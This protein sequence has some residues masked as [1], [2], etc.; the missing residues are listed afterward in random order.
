MANGAELAMI[1]RAKDEAGPVF[2]SVKGKAGGL[3]SGVGSM[4]DGI[5]RAGL[6]VGGIV[7]IG[8]AIAGVAS[9]MVSGN[10]EM[11]TYQTQLGTLLGGADKAKER[12]QQL[13][14]IGAETP[15]D[16]PQLVAAEKIMAGFGLTT[17]KTQQLTGRSLDDYRR[18]IGDMAAATGAPLDEVTLL[19]SK[20][21]SGATGEAISR[22]QELGIVTREQMAA[23]GV[24]FSKSGELVT[25]IPQAMKIAM[26]LANEKMGGGMKALSSTFAG[27]MSTLSDNFGQAKVLLMAPIF[28]VLRNGLT[29]VNEMLSS[30]TFTSA[31]T[32]MAET[33]AAAVKGMV[34]GIGAAMTALGPIFTQ[35]FS[36]DWIGA[37]SN[38]GALIGPALEGIGQTI[39]TTVEGWATAF[40][41]W[42]DGAD[43]GMIS[44]LA[45][46]AI[47]L[48]TWIL[49]A[50]AAIVEK[51]G[52][53]AGAFVD[54]IGP[55]IPPMLVALG[56][57]LSTMAGWMLGTALPMVISKLAEWGLAF[58][59]WVAP[60]IPPL[61][62][63]LGGLLL[64]LGGWIL[65]TALP[66]IVSKLLEWGTAFAAWVPGAA[67]RLLLAVGQ[68]EL[69]I[70]GWVGSAAVSLGAK[71]LEWVAVMVAW[72]LIAVIQL[73]GKLAEIVSAIGS[74]I[75]GA[76]GSLQERAK[77]LG[78][79]IVDGIKGAIS[80]GASAIANA[81]TGVL[82]A[83]LERAKA[84]IGAHSPS[85]MWWKQV[86]EPIGQGIVGGMLKIAPDIITAAQS[87][88]LP[89]GEIVNSAVSSMGQQALAMAEAA[90]QAAMAADK[91]RSPRQIAD[92]L[93]D[94]GK[95]FGTGV[96]LPDAIFRPNAPVYGLGG[97]GSLG[98]GG[99]GG[100]G[101]G[102]TTITV[103]LNAGTIV[104][105]RDLP[106]LVKESFIAGLRR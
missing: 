61:L 60:R 21:G 1:L 62:A 100:F 53:W 18:S 66:A 52:V 104:H 95:T 88:V 29:S 38:L 12:I 63:A 41:S 67:V 78:Q 76:V 83:A 45:E 49:N 13:A 4:I 15:F 7:A 39:A 17:E 82:D 87:M 75:S 65:T 91:A 26:D 58:V 36:G 73:P 31:I 98:G 90:R 47:G 23:M 105:E 51:L 11:E 57:Y 20:F 46:L 103:N 25:P 48:Y 102:D 89:V 6:A 79:A 35:A 106:G 97:I 30:E 77:A 32:S 92:I 14:K 81:A 99:A 33:G 96:S 9:S 64:D 93:G 55:K 22:L 16:L 19:W 69:Q 2:D 68:M 84:A 50:A 74:W 59:E 5:G 101:R 56:G 44:G 10:V 3:A 37:L 34:D 70:L 28:D 24:E 27:Q 54:W 40:A 86:G 85:E 8:G 43:T 72:P 94:L 80:A 42:I 71:L